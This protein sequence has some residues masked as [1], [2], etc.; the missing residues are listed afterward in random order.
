MKK[1]VLVL[2]TI[3]ILFSLM[4]FYQGCKREITFDNEP[5]SDISISSSMWMAWTGVTM[6]F[7][8][9]AEDED[10]D[11]LY[12]RWS[13]NKGNFVGNGSD[14]NKGSHVSW[15][16]PET[17]G[18]ATIK[19]VVSDRV[20][21]KSRSMGIVI[22]EE[23]PT[24]FSSGSTTI[25]DSGYYYVL[26]KDGWVVIPEASSVTIGEGVEILVFRRTGGIL[27]NGE[28]NIEGSGSNK[29]S[30][31]P[32]RYDG[33]EIP[34]RGIKYSG[35]E[36][37]GSIT[38]LILNSA[39]EGLCAE[40]GAIVE[41]TNSSLKDNSTYGLASYSYS[42]I[43]ASN[44]TIWDNEVGINIDNADAS[45]ISCSVRY[46]DWEGIVIL[47]SSERSDS[48]QGCVI[49]NSATGISIQADSL[50]PDVLPVINECS[51]FVPSGSEGY[52]IELSTFYT[53]T[54]PI[55]AEHN[56]FGS[57]YVDSLAISEIIYDKM[58][59]GRIG[60]VVDFIPFLTEDP[61]D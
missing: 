30:I 2:S 5:P 53:G 4:V 19:V 16:A 6:S 58:D 60:A 55:N 1:S 40:E 18:Y 7:S 28:L 27:V 24:Y 11:P 8:V 54:T 47:G 20:E 23:F 48:I 52:A 45:I 29:V 49:A 26:S 9:E 17:P 22:A 31:A 57:D 41:I 21:E 3:F 33:G 14:S 12:Y 32:Y 56:Y 59:N 34:W 13:A 35:Q 51:I 36:A 42:S 25:E 46:S 50:Y 38:H 15:E 10:G 39:S 44:C 37:Q 61:N 43:T